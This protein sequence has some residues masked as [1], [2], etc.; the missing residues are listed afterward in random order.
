MIWRKTARDRHLD[1]NRG[2]VGEPAQREGHDRA[3]PLAERF[4]RAEFDEGDEFVQHDLRAEQ[5][6][7]ESGLFPGDAD[8]E[9]HRR[10][11]PA[12]HLLE[13]QFGIAEQAAGPAEQAIRQRDERDEG[14]HHGAHRDRQLYAGLRALRGGF[15]DVGRL[16]SFLEGFGDL[17]FVRLPA[18]DQGARPLSADA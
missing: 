10:E 6:A 3:A 15:D 16:L 17:D 4:E 9:H 8:Q 13:A 7:C 1:G 5:P 14:Q 11:N 18:F 12:E 2:E